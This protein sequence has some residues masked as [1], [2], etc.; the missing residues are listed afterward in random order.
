LAHLLLIFFIVF[1]DSF[2]EIFIA[3]NS[4]LQIKFMAFIYSTTKTK[5][6]NNNNN[7]N[8]FLSSSSSLLLLLLLLFEGEEE[9]EY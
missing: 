7:N 2:I 1:L 6:N 4:I 3:F 5:N 9:E 8:S